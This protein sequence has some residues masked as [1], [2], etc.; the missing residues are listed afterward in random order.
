MPAIPIGVKDF[1]YAVQ[2]TDPAGGTPTYDTIYSIPA[3]KSAVFNSAAS[4]ARAYGDDGVQASAETVGD[5][6]L[7]IDLHEL[8][9][10]DKNR[11][12]GVTYSAGVLVN[13]AT[14]VSPYVACGFKISRNDGSYD[15]VWFPKV[16]FQKPSSDNQ[17]KGNAITFQSEMLEGAVVNLTA[18]N[19]WRVAVRTSDTN[20]AASTISNWFSNV[21]F[22]SGA[23]LGALTAVVAK[24]TT[25]GTITITKAGG[26]SFTIDT[27]TVSS[28][29]IPFYKGSSAEPIAGTYAFGGQGTAT[30]TITFTPT[31]AFGIV[32]VSAG[33]AKDKVVDT[34]GVYVGQAGAVWTSD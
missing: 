3:I 6:S 25:K 7:S 24:S 10:D 1:V 29:T 18:N 19:V 23:D 26:G 22:A 8:P 31:V 30:V 20:A 17:T 21:V 16:M 15:Y 9:Q 14:D 33:V 13:S 34:N 11:I 32:A 27:N 28:E 2:L 5:M 12:L 4:I